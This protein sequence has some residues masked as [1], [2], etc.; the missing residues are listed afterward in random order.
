[1]LS[2]WLLTSILAQESVLFKIAALAPGRL[3]LHNGRS[4]LQKGAPVYDVFDSW[5]PAPV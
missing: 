3:V 5:V 1:M 2:A 4:I